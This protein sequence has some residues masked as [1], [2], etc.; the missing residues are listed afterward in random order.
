MAWL[1]RTSIAAIIAACLLLCCYAVPVRAGGVGA[2]GD[3]S[4]EGDAGAM[5]SDVRLFEWGDAGTTMSSRS[6]VYS[7]VHPG[8]GVGTAG[9]D[10]FLEGATLAGISTSGEG[11]RLLDEGDTGS[12]VGTYHLEAPALAAASSRRLVEEGD[13][14]GD[15]GSSHLEG[16]EGNE[17][18]S[19]HAV[20]EGDA[21][22]NVGSSHLNRP[23]GIAVSDHHLREE[24]GSG[25]NAADSHP[26]EKDAAGG[27][28]ADSRP[29][30]GDGPGAEAGG[31]L[32]A[33]AAGSTAASY[34]PSK[35]VDAGTEAGSQ[36][37]A[38]TGGT[39][40]SRRHLSQA[41]KAKGPQCLYATNDKLGIG[42][43][44]YYW[45]AD[46]T[47]RGQLGGSND[48]GPGVARVRSGM[49]MYISKKGNLYIGEEGVEKQ[50]FG[51]E[52]GVLCGEWHGGVHFEERG[53]CTYMRRRVDE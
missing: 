4:E 50:W 14:G 23:A 34:R 33:A 41:A 19:H 15:V 45:A 31:R 44:V 37:G 47:F 46:G 25:T 40:A 36:L 8:G 26:V 17:A 32:H 30:K 1:S 11:R 16:P 18:S 21:G 10:P 7:S 5:Y 39:A 20:E 2:S 22:D 49:G 12:L 28:Q 48:S 24:D 42:T 27:I 52:R 43:G 53:I 6:S 38:A 13:A 3:G 29:V 9:G 51:M 35:E